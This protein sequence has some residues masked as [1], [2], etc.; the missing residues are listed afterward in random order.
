MSHMKS[1]EGYK[2]EHEISSDYSDLDIVRRSTHTVADTDK[3]I[4][5]KWDLLLLYGIGYATDFS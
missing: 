1:A 5:S 2:H 3:Y 4:Q